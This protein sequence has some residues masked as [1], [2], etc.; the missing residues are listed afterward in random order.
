M[1]RND[2][3]CNVDEVPDEWL[4][5]WYPETHMSQKMVMK[6]KRMEMERFKRMKVYRVVTRES[7][8]RDE[9]GKMISIKWVITKNGIEEHPIAKARVVAR[10]FNRNTRSDGDAKS[11]FLCDDEM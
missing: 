4:S 9:E 10:E 3:I 2:E 5:S 6:A 11:D 7:M 1:L 8:K